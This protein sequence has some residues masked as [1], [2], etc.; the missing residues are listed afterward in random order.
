M[1]PWG[2]VPQLLADAPG[3]P[4]SQPLYRCLDL[5]F[6]F[7]RIA[8][9][10]GFNFLHSSTHA[11]RY[12][13]EAGPRRLYLSLEKETAEVEF[14]F[15]IERLLDPSRSPSPVS[16]ALL[17]VHCQVTTMLDLTNPDVQ[18]L[19][20]TTPDEL[21]REW[22]EPDRHPSSITQQLGTTVHDHGRFSGI[23]F[24]SARH[25]TGKNVLIFPDRLDHGQDKVIL[26]LLDRGQTVHEEQLR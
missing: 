17:V 14:R 25:P 23:I 19:L 26:H 22:E 21:T 2:E 12:T 24:P 10:S 13:F 16:T 6:V 3:A 20:A 5:G 18:T 1:R 9:K 7:R 15:G 4:L 11:S 8:S